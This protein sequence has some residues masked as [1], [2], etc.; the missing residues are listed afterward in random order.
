M[1]YEGPIE[2]HVIHVLSGQ[3]RLDFISAGQFA[4]QEQAVPEDILYSAVS[5]FCGNFGFFLSTTL[6]SVDSYGDLLWT[7]TQSTLQEIKSL[8]CNILRKAL[9]PLEN[10]VCIPVQIRARMLYLVF[11]LLIW[12]SW[13]HLCTPALHSRFL[14]PKKLWASIWLSTSV[15]ISLSSFY[16]RSILKLNLMTTVPSNYLPNTRS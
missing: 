9:W 16:Q 3:I 12:L 7:E 1:I 5:L 4:L 15:P 8:S 6:V 13:S 11:S 10:V 2:K 14:E